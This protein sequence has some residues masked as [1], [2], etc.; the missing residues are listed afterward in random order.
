MIRSK[1]LGRLPAVIAIVVWAIAAFVAVATVTQT[2]RQDSWGPIIATGWLPA[3]LIAWLYS[4][5][6]RVPCWPRL[7]RLSGR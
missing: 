6:S 3:V 5:S 7:R 2:I 1:R 4:P